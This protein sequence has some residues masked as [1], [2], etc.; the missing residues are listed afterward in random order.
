[1]SDDDQKDNKGGKVTA[2]SIQAKVESE[3]RK[4][5][6]KGLEAKVKAKVEEI[7]AA[8]EVVKI[9]RQELQDL[10]E[11]NSALLDG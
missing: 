2:Q 8:E 7:D 5:K 11:D 4:G 3:I 6:L 10:L 1:M 9:K